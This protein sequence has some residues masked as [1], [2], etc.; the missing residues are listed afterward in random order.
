MHIHEIK[1]Y[2]FTRNDIPLLLIL[3]SEIDPIT[4]EIITGDAGLRWSVRGCEIP[5][6]VRS[7]SWFCGLTPR[8][9]FD[10]LRHSGYE[11]ECETNIATGMTK[12]YKQRPTTPDNIIDKAIQD[13][14][15]CRHKLAAIRLYQ[16]H[17]G[18][19]LQ[20]TYAIVQE[21]ADNMQR[22]GEL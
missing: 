8:N 17:Y 19:E 22:D 16:E 4:G 2:Q 15:R 13:M 7:G 6:P 14:I 12:V 3:G 10:W 1:S 21:I 11:L 9:M 5:F 18:T 20:Q